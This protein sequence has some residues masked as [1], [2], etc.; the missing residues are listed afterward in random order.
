MKKKILVWSLTL[1]LLAGA[2]GVSKA[3]LPEDTAIEAFPIVAEL[4]D[5][6]VGRNLEVTITD[7]HATRRVTDVKGWSAEGTWLVV[8]L[9]AS[10]VATQDGDL[11]GFAELTIGDR[12]FTATD[13]GTTFYKQRLITGVPRAGSL[14]FELPADALTGTGILRLGLPMGQPREVLLDDVIELRVD[15]DEL[16]VEA[17]VTLDENGWAR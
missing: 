8:D 11:L 16:P 13:R 14:A 6:A 2:W 12:R 10:T 5:P 17:E 3:T 9:Q 15:L 1:V 7:I 4:D